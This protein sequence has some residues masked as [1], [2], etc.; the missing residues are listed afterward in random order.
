M[1]SEPVKRAPAGLED[2]VSMASVADG[3]A[4]DADILGASVKAEKLG[5]DLVDGVVAHCHRRGLD[6]EGPGRPVPHS[7]PKRPETASWGR[8]G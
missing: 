5:L 8:A 1:A 2:G 3:D 7:C 6:Y 4:V